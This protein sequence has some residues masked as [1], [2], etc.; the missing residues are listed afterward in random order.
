MASAGVVVNSS[1][2]CITYS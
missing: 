2:A 1:G